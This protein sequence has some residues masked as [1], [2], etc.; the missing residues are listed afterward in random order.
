MHRLVEAIGQ[1]VKEPVEM[2]SNPYLRHT[3]D[4]N[5]VIEVSVNVGARGTLRT[6]KLY[7]TKTCLLFIGTYTQEFQHS[8]LTKALFKDYVRM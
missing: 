8:K 1:L 4:D 2:S 3:E 5:I 7:V 6:S